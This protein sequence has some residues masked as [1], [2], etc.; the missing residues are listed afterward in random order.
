MPRATLDADL[1]ADIRLEQAEP[2]AQAWRDAFY[3]DVE[4][5]RDAVRRQSSFNLIHLDTLF[6]VDIFVPKRRAF[7]QVQFTRRVPHLLP[8]EPE[9][10][11]YLTTAEDTI[12]TKLEWYR[13]GGE[14]SERQ[15]RDVL[16]VCKVQGHRL[17]LEYLRH[18]ATR[19]G[20]LDLWE[21]AFSA[22]NL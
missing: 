20:V 9:R 2:L 22:A 7:D 6:K 10:T 11:I 3:V 1:V 18:W 4:A 14:V 5:I 19:L 8:T 13:I 17:D 15:W 16:G 21:R 12:L